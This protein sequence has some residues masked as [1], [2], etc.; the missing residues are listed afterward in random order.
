MRI[1]TF[2]C[3]SVRKRLEAILSWLDRHNPD[4]LALQETK[5]TDDAFPASAFRE[6]G[7][8]VAF[9]GEKSYNGVA[10][11]TREE[12]DSVQFGL[13]DDDGLSEARFCHLELGG[14]HILNAYVPQGSALDSAKFQFKLE[15]LARVR[16]FLEARFDPASD[17]V[18]WVGDLNVAPTAADVHDPKSIWPH[19]CYCQEVLDAFQDVTGWGLID[20]FRK[21]LPDPGT[22]TF[23]DYRVR[24][25][26]ERNVGWRIDHVLATEAA[27]GASRSCAVDVEARK[28]EGPSDHTFVYADFA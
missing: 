27:A 22:F 28:A 18:V 3:N 8:K 7:W 12:P 10:V 6:A 17:R 20:V 11:A 15:W 26:V 24:N 23:W 16:T 9:R 21:H 14:V 1:A 5:C 4:V 13:G 2:N 19:V 25:A